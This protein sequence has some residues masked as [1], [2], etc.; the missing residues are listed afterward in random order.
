MLFGL[1]NFKKTKI[2]NGIDWLIRTIL[3]KLPNSNFSKKISLKWGHSYQGNKR[4]VYTRSRLKMELV[5]T[6]YLQ[7][8][9]YYTGTFEE[10]CLK[11]LR[12]LLEPGDCFLDI[13]ANIGLYTLES[14]RIVGDNGVVYAFEPN[15]ENYRHLL[16]NTELNNLENVKAMNFGIGDER[17]KISLRLPKNGNKGEYT[18]GDVEGEIIED[19]NIE[20][21]DDV[22]KKED[23]NKINLVKMDIE[24][25]EID[26][27]KG[28]RETINKYR[29]VFLIEIWKEALGR[30]KYTPAELV[31]FFED[32]DYSGKELSTSGLK[33][34]NNPENIVEIDAIFIPNEKKSKIMEKVFNYQQ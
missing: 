17:T 16:R 9:I 32:M 10:H 30:F 7:N 2:A 4:I 13:G 21:M 22:V 6:D 29:P 33:E 25:A 34:L 27:L 20:K 3:R 26:A 12:K 28:M 23:I 24:G 19:V 15:S 1:I 31:K 8:Q 5:P 18:I 14:A 11:V